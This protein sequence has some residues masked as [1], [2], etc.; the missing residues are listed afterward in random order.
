MQVDVTLA[1][2]VAGLC[3]FLA[4][5]LAIYYNISLPRFRFKS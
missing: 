2:I 1:A 4:R 3:I 5:L